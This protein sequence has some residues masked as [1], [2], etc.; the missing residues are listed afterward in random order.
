MNEG[1]N[2]GGRPVAQPGP[3]P[4]WA[5]AAS[6]RPPP[7]APPQVGWDG[8][9]FSAWP[10]ASIIPIALLSLSRSLG[11]SNT[12]AGR[13]Q[14]VQA[15]GLATSACLPRP[16]DAGVE[17]G[18]ASHAEEECHLKMAAHVVSHAACVRLHP[19]ATLGWPGESCMDPMCPAA[20]S[21]QTLR[22]SSL[23]YS[24][25]PQNCMPHCTL[26]CVASSA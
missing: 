1:I 18:I 20:I 17:A 2:P 16:A 7:Q 12:Q 22:P 24:V 3:S 25:S 14:V 6:C 21:F 26:P 5:P 10:A 8:W 13:L 19:P 11:G 9:R 23:S 4:G 15:A